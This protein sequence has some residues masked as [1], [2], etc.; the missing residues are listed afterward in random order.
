MRLH[1][2]LPD[3]LVAELDARIG[4]R[5]RSP[6]LVGLIRR[7]LDDDQRWDELEAAIGSIDDHGHEWDENPADWVRAQRADVRRAG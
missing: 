2:Q 3:E 5:R 4:A 6:F 7:A 1:I